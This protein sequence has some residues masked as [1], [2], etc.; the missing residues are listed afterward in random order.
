MSVIIFSKNIGPVPITCLISEKHSSEIEITGNPV[1]DGSQINDHAY[2]KPKQITIEIA[3]ENATE[4][5]NALVRFQETR[6][7]FVLVTGLSV[8]SNMLIQAIDA[9]RDKSLSNVLR[10][11]I[12][13]REVVIVNT[14]RVTEISSNPQRGEPGGK[15]SLKSTT[16]SSEGS[17]NQDTSDRASQKVQRGDS[18]SKTVPEEK[19]KSILKGIFT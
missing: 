13:C 2:I 7:P 11:T 8:Y 12:I 16:P 18:P 6:A 14:S 3:D 5:Y 9:T 10:A 4:S 1:E 15:N 19:S 17:T